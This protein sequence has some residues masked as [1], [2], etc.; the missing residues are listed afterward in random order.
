MHFDM[1]AIFRLCP[2][3]TDLCVEMEVCRRRNLCKDLLMLVRSYGTQLKSIGTTIRD[4][5]H[6]YFFHVIA[7]NCP[8]ASLTACLEGDGTEILRILGPQVQ[9][10][11]IADSAWEFPRSLSTK[12]SKVENLTIGLKNAHALFAKPKPKLKSLD[13]M[14]ADTLYARREILSDVA[15]NIGRLRT[16][17]LVGPR[18]HRKSLEQLASSNKYM[19]TM[20]VEL[21]EPSSDKVLDFSSSYAVDIIESFSPCQFLTEIS[22]NSHSANHS[23]QLIAAGKFPSIEN[24][25]VSLR[26]QYLVVRVYS[27]HYLS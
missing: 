20:I 27:I 11:D 12:C 19:E 17:K 2:L 22:F 9:T 21:T 7:E 23:K 3:V 13:L 14:V 8:N 16:L 4:S 26:N 18:I 6:C 15:N 5:L 25:C 24:A 10:M 1:K